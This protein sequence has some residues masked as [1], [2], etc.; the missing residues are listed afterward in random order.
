MKRISNSKNEIASNHLGI[1]AKLSLR[2]W[3][4]LPDHVKVYLDLEELI[5][6]T[7]LY[8]SIKS[9]R[10]DESKA[11]ESTFVYWL[12]ESYLKNTVV[13]YRQP[14]YAASLV[15]PIDEMIAVDEDKPR[16]PGRLSTTLAA[17][18]IDKV[19]TDDKH[20]WEEGQWLDSISGFEKLLQY[21]SSSLR[22]ALE[23]FFQ[24]R[25]FGSIPKND[26]SE[27]RDL[28]KQYG[29]SRSDFEAVLKVV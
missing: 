9:E 15:F 12:A 2:Y 20:W 3:K 10:Y 28:V 7:V 8:V 11:A 18:T 25:R 4:G 24:N 1:I 23:R 26:L 21:A 29:V 6:D 16:I 27:L 17:K 22:N 14:K 5:A 13:K 19:A